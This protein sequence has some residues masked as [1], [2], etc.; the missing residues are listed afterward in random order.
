[1]RN[2][3]FL[4]MVFSMM[5]LV[6][7]MPVQAK[8]MM[9]VV[10]GIP[11]GSYTLDKHHTSLTFTVNHLGFS[12]YTMSFDNIDARL[13]IDPAH[14]E[15]A[16]VGAVIDPHSLD[17][18]SPPVGFIGDVMGEKWLNAVRFPEIKFI[19]TKIDVTGDKTANI[20][21]NLQLLG[22]SKP[23]VLSAVFNGGYM[24][25]SM[26][27]N[28]RAGFSART[29]FKRSDFGMV[30]GIPEPGTT[31]GVSDEVLVTIEAEFTGPALK[32]PVSSKNKK[33]GKKQ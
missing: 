19:S 24:G 23:I 26:D 9:P 14:P 33:Q 6:P 11:A 2:S 32:E 17:L 31:M 28:A 7:I 30:Y 8:N 16:R 21:G 3:M 15:K 27:P 10:A 18:P 25:H 29:S 13:D 12:N 4:A 5:V 22:V 20:Y 1:M